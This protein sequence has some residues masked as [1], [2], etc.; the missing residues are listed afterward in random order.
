M[1]DIIIGSVNECFRLIG[2]KLFYENFDIIFMR[3][4]K[5][6]LKKL[7]IFLKNFSRYISK[8]NALKLSVNFFLLILLIYCIIEIYHN[9]IFTLIIDYVNVILY[10]SL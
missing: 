5:R 6:I 7:M 1:W 9:K 10:Q 4:M 3:N 2:N 8:T